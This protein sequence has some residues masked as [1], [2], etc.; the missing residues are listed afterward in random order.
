[1]LRRAL[2]FLALFLG[3]LGLLLWLDPE[4]GGLDLGSSKGHTVVAEGGE[5]GNAMLKGRGEYTH[6]KGNR[7]Q[8]E[9]RFEDSEGPSEDVTLKDLAIRLF[10]EQ[11]DALVAEVQSLRGFTRLLQGADALE[12]NLD[13]QIRFEDVAVSLVSGSK[14]VPLTLATDWLQGD[15]EAGWFETEARATVTGSGIEGEGTGLSMDQS[16]G[17]LRFDKDARA[18]ITVGTSSP[19]TIASGG[20][21]EIRRASDDSLWVVAD[22]QAFL[23]I[24]GTDTMQLQARTIEAVGRLLRN[25]ETG[26]EAVRFDSLDARG[27]VELRV[28]GNVLTGQRAEFELDPAGNLLSVRLSGA[29]TGTLVVEGGELGPGQSETLRIWGDGPLVVGQVGGLAFQMGGPAQLEWR[30]AELWAAGGISSRSEGEG[31]SA[32]I[33]AWTDV[34]LVRGPWKLSAPELTGVASG[35]RLDVTTQGGSRL[36]GTASQGE[37]L[38][39]LAQSGFQFNL[40]DELWEVTRAE[41]VNLLWDDGTPLTAS[42]DR[43]IEF[44]PDGPQ[45]TAEGSVEVLSNEQFLRGERL[46]VRGQ[47]FLDLEGSVDEG[48]YLQRVQFDL[49]EGRVRALRVTRDGNLLTAAGGVLA[50]LAVEGLRL[51]VKGDTLEVRGPLDRPDSGV[52]RP[53]EVLAEGNVSAEMA[54]AGVEDSERAYSLTSSWLRVRR[55]PLP[56]EGEALTRI[57][58]RGTVRSRIT[59]FDGDY[60][61]RAESLDAELF[62]PYQAVDDTQDEVLAQLFRGSLLAEGD[63]LVEKLDGDMFTGYGQRFTLDDQGRGVLEAE[64]GGATRS[65]GQLLTGESFEMTAG[66]LQ[67]DSTRFNALDPRILILGQEGAQDDAESLALAELVASAHSMEATPRRLSFEGD[68]QLSARTIDGQQW[69]LAAEQARFDRRPNAGTEGGFT[70]LE[71]LVAEQ[72][73]LVRFPAGEEANGDRLVADPLTQKVRLTG[74]CRMNTDQLFMV[75]EWVEYDAVTGAVQ[76]GP[77]FV[78]GRRRD[79]RPP[80]S[81]EDFDQG[82]DPPTTGDGSSESGSSESGEGRRP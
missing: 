74:R 34:E 56:G 50:D 73:V 31:G 11:D 27:E 55:E 13:S 22:R 1:M 81:A 64:P 62:D 80:P 82:E 6:F 48:G 47:E 75:Y 29:P 59:E 45:F 46:T 16:E 5:R 15:L 79:F 33:R 38:L 76:P 19:G 44:R 17:L 8:Y 28:R 66:R 24:E 25:A 26:E 53:V 7:R 57:W 32:S 9:L 60:R 37:E 35:R 40:E 4:T 71:E 58:A 61:V 2:A 70:T 78:A 10:D 63:V 14:L 52:G 18:S 36:E 67:F 3:S 72:D 43:L 39:L 68:A 65:K 12:A 21:L 69:F 23:S 20:P 77:G 42:A 51:D 41:N 49:P 30:D 54:P